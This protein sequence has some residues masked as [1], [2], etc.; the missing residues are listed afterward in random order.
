MN[1][2]KINVTPL[3]DILLV[4][5][6][7]FMVISPEKLSRFESQIPSEPDNS[8]PVIPHPETLQVT[9]GTDSA[10]SINTISGFGS[11]DEPEKL[12][13]KLSTVFNER[14]RSNKRNGLGADLAER[15]VFIKAPKAAPYGSVARVIDAVK[16]SGARPISLLVD[17]LN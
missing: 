2:P 5:L 9:L 8:R 15:T 10:L 3:I 4:L 16:A 17:G 6:I 11:V 1:H 12:T 14:E 13:E 7:I